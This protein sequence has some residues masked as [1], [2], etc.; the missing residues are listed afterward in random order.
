MD[1]ISREE[2]KSP[3]SV[4]SVADVIVLDMGGR[5]YV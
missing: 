5:G 3:A 2:W 1:A 4:S